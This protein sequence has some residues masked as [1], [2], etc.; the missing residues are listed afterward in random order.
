MLRKKTF[1]STLLFALLLSQCIWFSS[2]TD[3][4]FF[5]EDTTPSTE[6][7]SDTTDSEAETTASESQAPENTK[8]PPIDFGE[9]Y[10]GEYDD[11]RIGDYR[12]KENGG[13]PAEL[14]QVDLGCFVYRLRA[15]VPFHEFHIYAFSGNP[16]FRAADFQVEVSVLEPEVLEVTGVD[17][18]KVVQGNSTLGGISVKALS[19]GVAHVF[20]K[21]THIPTGGSDTLQAIVIVR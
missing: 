19:P 15:G 8:I 7:V 11:L 14:L 20:I 21:T 10:E 13:L 5:E 1:R 6:T 9:S 3:P 2:C 17:S 4:F 16:E 18:Q 12:T